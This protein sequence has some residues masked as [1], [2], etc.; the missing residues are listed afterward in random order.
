MIEKKKNW[1]RRH[2]IWTGIIIF[3]SIFFVIGTALDLRDDLEDE[4]GDE[5]EEDIQRQYVKEDL[6]ELIVLFV[7]N[8]Y[9]T[10][11][12]KEEEF[13]NYKDK[14]IKSSGA[15]KE[16]KTVMLSNSIVVVIINPNNIYLRGATIYFKSSEK[17]KLLEINPH[18]EISFEGRI[19]SYGSLMGII[20]K[21]AELR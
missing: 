15:V 20:I 1:F 6:Y 13:K 7:N 21:D 12:Q 19:E 5:W 18:D 10:E 2:P 17:D 14:W 8:D 4:E 16:V 9:Y 11:L 3:F